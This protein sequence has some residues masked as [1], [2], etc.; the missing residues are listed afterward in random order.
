M[1]D[2]RQYP[3]LS[4]RDPMKREMLARRK[5]ENLINA[6]RS[7]R[8]REEHAFYEARDETVASGGPFEKSIELSSMDFDTNE[9]TPERGDFLSGGAMLY[10]VAT[11]GLEPP[12]SGL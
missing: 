2:G 9:C 11:G 8:G 4:R 10:M 12:T 1:Y 5:N 3:I 6:A 7:L